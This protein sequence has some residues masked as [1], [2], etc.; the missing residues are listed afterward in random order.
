MENEQA[1]TE[2]EKQAKCQRDEI[3]R[4]RVDK[5]RLEQDLSTETARLKSLQSELEW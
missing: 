2:S 1:N 3:D 4:L 5:H